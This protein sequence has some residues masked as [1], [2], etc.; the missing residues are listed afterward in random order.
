MDDLENRSIE[1]CLGNRCLGISTLVYR[2]IIEVEKNL[3]TILIL[4]TL[5]YSS[6][7]EY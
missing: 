1:A 4:G 5:M 3:S 6:H 7:S 2:I